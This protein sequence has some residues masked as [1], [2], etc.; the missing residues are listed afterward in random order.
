MAHPVNSRYTL[1]NNGGVWGFCWHR[2]WR[3]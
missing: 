2:Q 1:W 3:L